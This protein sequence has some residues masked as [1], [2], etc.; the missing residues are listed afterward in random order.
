MKRS[1]KTQQSVHTTNTNKKPKNFDDFEKRLQGVATT[2]SYPWEIIY[3]LS[4][5]ALDALQSGTPQLVSDL[6]EFTHHKLKLMLSTTPITG[7][8]K[9]ATQSIS[10]SLFHFFQVDSSL[11]HIFT[12]LTNALVSYILRSFSSKETL[13]LVNDFKY[14]LEHVALCGYTC[15]D[16]IVIEIFSYLQLLSH[17]MRAS[18]Q[19]RT[20]ASDLYQEKDTFWLHSSNGASLKC[21]W[22]YSAKKKKV[23]DVG[24]TLTPGTRRVKD[25]VDWQST[26][27]TDILNSNLPLVLDVGCGYGVSLLGLA[28][29]NYFTREYGICNYIGVDL[30]SIAITYANSIAVKWN[31]HDTCQFH[32]AP[33][34]GF[35]QY[36]HQLYKGPIVCILIQYP[37]PYK[38][39]LSQK[40]TT[41]TTQQ[42]KQSN[43]QLPTEEEGFMV[44]NKLL[45][46]SLELLAIHGILYL[47]SN[48]EDV[49]VSMKI[50]IESNDV[51][52]ANEFEYLNSEDLSSTQPPMSTVMTQ[53]QRL[54]AERGGRLAEGPGWLS[55]SPFGL[56]ARTET[57]AAYMIDKKPI[58]RIGWTKTD[59]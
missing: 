11:T 19:E 43:S 9:I 17:D 13:L 38:L 36:I 32:I 48:V 26:I 55:S 51:Y 44:T 29:S 50:K 58:Y 34:E 3:H 42:S 8:W 4:N 18:I 30:S 23:R 15:K 21:L 52:K 53:R 31:M 2:T 54:W 33:V 46:I 37:T 20:K 39:S 6:T 24:V 5:F 28:K 16:A 57:E 1:R 14:M 25:I 22:E 35:F 7:D 12:C 41:T 10:Q 47:Q 27:S 56:S 59:V 45:S 40:T 49:A